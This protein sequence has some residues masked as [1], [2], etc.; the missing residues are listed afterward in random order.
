MQEKLMRIGEVVNTVGIK[1]MVKVLLDSNLEVN[2][3]ANLKLCFYQTSAKSFI[4]LQIKTL[5]LKKNT[6]LIAFHDLNHINDVQKF[7]N[8]I[9][10]VPLANQAFSLMPIWTEY[11]ITSEL[12]EG[13]IIDWMNNSIQNLIKIQIQDHQFWVPM[14][15]EYVVCQNDETKIIQLKNIKGLM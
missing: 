14:V 15:D 1:G 11:K 10:Y 8:L 2:D 4:P 7:K 9:L 3:L 6:L 13:K 12:G 5:E